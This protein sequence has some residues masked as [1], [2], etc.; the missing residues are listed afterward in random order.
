M[1]ALLRVLIVGLAA[2]RLARAVSVDTITDPARAWLYEAAYGPDGEAEGGWGWRWIYGLLSC[3]YCCGFWISLGLYA[4]WVNAG[5][6][7]PFVAAVAVAGAASI[8]FGLDR[9]MVRDD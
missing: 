5:G 1:T 8:L 3:G 4:L 9:V 7:R 6:S 2:Y